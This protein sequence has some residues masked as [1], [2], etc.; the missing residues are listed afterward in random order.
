MTF[1][2]KDRAALAQAR[3]TVEELEAKEQEAIDEFVG[4]C[5]RIGLE[6][7]SGHLWRDIVKRADE[8]RDALEPFASG[9]RERAAPEDDIPF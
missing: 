1:T 6:L 2:P 9:M 8:L 5:Q 7:E 3:R 4:V